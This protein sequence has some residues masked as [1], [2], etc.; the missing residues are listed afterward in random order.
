MCHEDVIHPLLRVE[1]RDLASLHGKY[2]LD[3]PPDH[4]EAMQLAYKEIQADKLVPPVE[5]VVEEPIVEFEAVVE[6]EEEPSSEVHAYRGCEIVGGKFDYKVKVA[7]ESDFVITNVTVSIIAYPQ[8]CM[9]LGGEN[10]KTILRSVDSGVL[11][12][13]SIPQRT[14]YRARW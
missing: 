13:L 8:D 12:S 14:A 10:V 9:E 5:A 6:G 2:V 4:A 7:N 3:I 11:S 1:T